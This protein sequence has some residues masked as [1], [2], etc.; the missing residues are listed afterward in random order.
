MPRPPRIDFPHA[1]YHVTSRGNGRAKIFQSDDDR[2]RF[3]AQFAHHLRLCVV[4]VYAFA[5]MDKTRPHPLSRAPGEPFA[6]HAAIDVVLLALLVR[7]HG[8][9]QRTVAGPSP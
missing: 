6:F 8:C 1:V 2:R 4:D 7:I 3:L 5:L 9:S